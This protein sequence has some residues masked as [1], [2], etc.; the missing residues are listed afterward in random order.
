MVHNDLGYSPQK[1]PV[2]TFPMLRLQT[3]ATEPSLLHRFWGS[4]LRPLVLHSRGFPEVT[5]PAPGK[6]VLKEHLYSLWDLWF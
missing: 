4:E 6:Y 5:S 3:F 2:Y 1:P